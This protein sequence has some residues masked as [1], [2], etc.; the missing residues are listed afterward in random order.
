[1]IVAN[2]VRDGKAFDSDDNSLEVFWPGGTQAFPQ[3]SKTELATE[4]VELIAT[5]FELSRG[6]GTEPRFSVISLKE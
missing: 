1:M 4:L 5:R 3:A 6:A 2:C